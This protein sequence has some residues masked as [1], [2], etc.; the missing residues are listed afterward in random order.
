MIVG[1]TA[2][3]NDDDDDTYKQTPLELSSALRGMELAKG[4]L[5]KYGRSARD[6]WQMSAL[7]APPACAARASR[8]GG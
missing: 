4:K 8:W 2:D 1:R 3:D 7:T 6:Y 5:D